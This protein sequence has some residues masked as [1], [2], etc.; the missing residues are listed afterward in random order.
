VDRRAFLTLGGVSGGAAAL[1]SACS[2]ATA[3]T[4]KQID[5]FADL[6]WPSAERRRPGWVN[7]RNPGAPTTLSTPRK[8]LVVG[9]G[10]AGLSAALELVEAG[11]QV[12]VREAAPELGGRLATRDLDPGLGRTFRVEH[13]LHMWFDNYWVFKDIRARLGLNQFRPYEAVNFVFR[14]YAPERLESKP[15]V[16]PL[17]LMRLVSESP[18]LQWE[19][20][21]GSIGIFQDVL[22]FRMDGLYDRL[23]D[24]SFFDWMD[25]LKVAKRFKDVFLQPAAH[26]TLNRQ[27]DLSAAEMVLYQ[28]IYF[29]S[30]PFAFDREITTVDH[31]TGVIDPW[32]AYLRAKGATVQTSA[33]VPGLR[34]AGDRI[35][36]V[37][38]ESETYDWVVLAADVNATK[39][40][41]AGSIAADDAGAA[42]LAAMR[43]RVS[44]VGVAPPYRI[45]R[46]WTDRQLDPSR[47][48]VIETP[49]HDPIALICQF[50]QLE[51]ECIDWGNE[52]GGAILEFHLYA[53]EDELIHAPDDEVWPHIRPTA[54]EVVPE[55][56]DANVIGQTIGNYDNFSSFSMGEGK[57]RPRVESARE[58][59]VQ[60]VFFCGDWI[61]GPVPSALME[62]A[63]LTGRLAANECRF[64]DGVREVGYAHTAMNGP[65]A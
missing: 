5:D 9:G 48:D 17:N 39:A 4:V 49:Q 23:D 36:G 55:L 45:L 62:R 61:H 63:V 42:G 54:L 33:P 21:L 10:L 24:E 58:D 18:N 1:L 47:P 46:I 44:R 26:V 28:H 7:P 19:D 3:P 53:L 40:I 11:Y 30:Q 34:F 41:L 51:Q 13:G 59:G 35:T 52:T 50:H 25:R 6:V 64:A 37:V 65:M 57:A 8:A 12:T 60:N 27:Y 38:G 22:A 14:D 32:V 56:A 20:I 43:T 2:P 15:R 31:A 16:F 29:I